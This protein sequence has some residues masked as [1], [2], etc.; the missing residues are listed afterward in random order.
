MCNSQR[1]MYVLGG[2]NGLKKEFSY[3][4][5]YPIKTAIGKLHNTLTAAGREI[6]I[7]GDFHLRTTEVF[8][9]ERNAAGT[10]LGVFSPKVCNQT[11]ICR[12]LRLIV[13]DSTQR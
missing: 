3:I 13:T 9:G 1:L 2:K 12:I 8:N 6:V 10:G 5:T 4:H 7:D 11:D